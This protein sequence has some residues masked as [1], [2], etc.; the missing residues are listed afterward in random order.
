M[1][2]A[3]ERD[4][5]PSM[6]RVMARGSRNIPLKVKKGLVYLHDGISEAQ[7]RRDVK[8]DKRAKR[9]KKTDKKMTDDEVKTLLSESLKM[10]KESLGLPPT[11]PVGYSYRITDKVLEGASKKCKEYLDGVKPR[12]VVT[13]YHFEIM[14]KELAKLLRLEYED[15]KAYKKALSSIIS[16]IEAEVTSE[17]LSAISLSSKNGHLLVRIVN[18]RG[19]MVTMEDWKLLRLID[20]H[21]KHIDLGLLDWGKQWE[22]EPLLEYS[23]SKMGNLYAVYHPLQSVLLVACQLTR[24]TKNDSVAS[25]T[26]GKADFIIDQDYL[27]CLYLTIKQLRA[28]KKRFDELREKAEARVV[29]NV[30]QLFDLCL[31][32]K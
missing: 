21:G 31:F 17:H 15:D 7:E 13:T 18:V 16:K 30:D 27:V 26:Y 2:Y 25:D 3:G 20:E 28:N 22:P 24:K 8:K 6:L 5:C 9:N 1:I 29:T 32:E 12:G 23:G 10:I 19:E 14:K 11:N 4:F